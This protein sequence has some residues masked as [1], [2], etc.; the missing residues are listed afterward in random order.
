MKIKQ[1]HQPSSSFIYLLR[2]DG[3]ERPPAFFY[4]VQVEDNKTTTK[5]ERKTRRPVQI[6]PTGY[7]ET[8]THRHTVIGAQ[9][10]P[11]G[12]KKMAITRDNPEMRCSMG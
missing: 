7:T 5:K 4:F 1:H 3:I 12:K 11:R 9:N 8:H 2:L 6:I 10:I